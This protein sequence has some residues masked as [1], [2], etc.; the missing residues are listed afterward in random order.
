MG[1]MQTT[2]PPWSTATKLTLV[3]LLLGLGIFLLY[4]FQA[5]IIPLVLAVILAYILLPLTNFIQGRLRVRRGFAILLA[6]LVL[7]ICLTAIPMLLIPPLAAQ[8]TELNLDI[9]R[10]WGEIESLLGS[11]YVIAGQT[12]D[13]RRLCARR[14]ARSA[15]CWSHSSPKPCS[16]PSSLSPLWS[17]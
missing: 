13:L 6:Y 9:Q 2:R 16:L 7:I 1:G 5:I 12:I 11:R 8:A 14:P 15:V 4:H 17:G 3:L 10:I